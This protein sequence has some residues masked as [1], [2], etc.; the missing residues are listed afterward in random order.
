MRISNQVTDKERHYLANL[1]DSGL[2]Y[3]PLKGEKIPQNV[4]HQ[5]IVDKGFIIGAKKIIRNDSL[6]NSSQR[7]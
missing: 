6:Q 5:F 2:G 3:I 1:L 7:K 4:T